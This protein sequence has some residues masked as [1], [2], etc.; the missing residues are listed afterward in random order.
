MSQE[1]RCKMCGSEVANPDARRCPSCGY[2][3]RVHRKWEVIHGFLS[4]VFIVSVIGIPV[5]I[6]TFLKSRRHLRER[7]AGI[8][9]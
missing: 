3:A 4:F 7:K 8:S 6:Y 2:D 5:G 1:A 9:G